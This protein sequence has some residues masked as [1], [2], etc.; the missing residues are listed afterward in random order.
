MKVIGFLVV[1][2]S[3]FTLYLL[4]IYNTSEYN[5]ALGQVMYKIKKDGRKPA[6]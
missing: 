3:A 2:L 6:V 1:L 5:P 4:F